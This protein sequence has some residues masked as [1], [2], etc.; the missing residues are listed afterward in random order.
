[1]NPVRTLCVA[2]FV[3]SSFAEN[4]RADEDEKHAR[5]R[6]DAAIKAAGGRK[7]LEKFEKMTWKEEGTYYGMGDGLPYT[8]NYAVH[9]PD[10][11]RMEIVDVFIT[12]LNGDEGWVKSFDEV[13][14]MTEEQ[15]AEQKLQLHA[16]WLSHLIAIRGEDFELEL[17][18]TRKLG[19]SAVTGVKVK[20]KGQRDVDLY[21]DKNTDLLK[22]AAYTIKAPELDDKDVPF[23]VYYLEYKEIDG[24]KLA[25]KLEMKQD[26]KLFIEAK[27][28]E[29]K[30]IEKFDDETFAKP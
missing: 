23:E 8:G 11:F 7:S 9:F 22:L 3:L 18:G 10:K 29:M 15:V 12:V 28:S 27:V 6:I 2:L 25:T 19:E 24:A 30:P 26:G 13:N 4:V 1:M 16:S 17:I 20:R 14:E 5:Y 21:F